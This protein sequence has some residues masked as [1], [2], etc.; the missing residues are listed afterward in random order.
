MSIPSYWYKHT[1]D[2]PQRKWRTC[3]MSLGCDHGR[4]GAACDVDVDVSRAPGAACDAICFVVVLCFSH[5]IDCRREHPSS[6]VKKAIFADKV[7]DGT[8]HTHTAHSRQQTAV[9][10][11]IDR[12]V[13]A[14]ARAGEPFIFRR[15]VCRI[16]SLVA[17]HVTGW[18]N[19]V[20][21]AACTCACVICVA[22][23]SVC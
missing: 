6:E 20:S 19:Q 14:R 3:G 10:T 2:L 4:V 9:I 15:R 18:R 23:V 5:C 21:C 22:C 11:R 13:A 7:S 1:E 17:R 12:D 16:R 8:T